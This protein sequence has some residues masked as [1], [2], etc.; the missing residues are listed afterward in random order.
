M[1]YLWTR[2]MEIVLGLGLED[3]SSASAVCPRLTSLTRTDIFYTCT[4]QHS[5][6]QTIKPGLFSDDSDF[7]VCLVKAAT[8]WTN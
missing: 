5:H 7:I 1:G 8:N 4:R 2:K 3:L 6:R